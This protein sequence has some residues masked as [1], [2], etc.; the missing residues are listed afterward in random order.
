MQIGSEINIF[1]L[2]FI[3]DYQKNHIKRMKTC[4]QMRPVYPKVKLHKQQSSVDKDVISLRR[5]DSEDRLCTVWAS[6]C[7]Q[8]DAK[9][10]PTSRQDFDMIWIWISTWCGFE[11]DFSMHLNMISVWILMLSWFE[12][13]LFTWFWMWFSLFPN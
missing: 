5:A 13:G 3:S 10:H 4:I 9:M 2:I 7:S 8:L 1:I 12:C 6:I 11:H